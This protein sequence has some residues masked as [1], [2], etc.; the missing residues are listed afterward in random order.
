MVEV[1]GNVLA[2]R[3]APSLL[4]AYQESTLADTLLGH[5]LDKCFTILDCSIDESGLVCYELLAMS[6]RVSLLATITAVAGDLGDSLA[7]CLVE[8]ALLAFQLPLRLLGLAG[9]GSLLGWGS[10]WEPVGSGPL[11]VPCAVAPG[12]SNRLFVVSVFVSDPS[13]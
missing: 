2:L 4:L 10:F 8:L 6:P 9:L 11:T 7:C 3:V 5:F 13:H 1:H 12:A